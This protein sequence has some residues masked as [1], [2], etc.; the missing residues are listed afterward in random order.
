EGTV[1]LSA[2]RE[3]GGL[4]ARGAAEE[5]GA[6]GVPDEIVFEV[7]DTGIGIAPEHMDRL[8]QAFSQAE[9]STTRRFGGTGL[10]LTISRSFCQMMRGDITVASAAGQGS[11]FTVRL[12]AQV[13]EPAAPEPPM[14]LGDAVGAEAQPV[15]VVPEPVGPG[16]APSGAAAVLVIEDDPDVRQLLEGVLT[17]EGY[18]VVT[19]TGTSDGLRLAHEVHP[20]AITLDL[21]LPGLEGWSL[22]SAIKSDPELGEVP[23][24]VLVVAGDRA[25]AP[26]GAADYLTKPVDRDRLAAVLRRHCVD[27]QAPVLVIDDDPP[28]REMLRRMLEREGFRVTEAGDG[29]AGLERVA[30]H[31]PSLVLLDLLMPGLDGFGFLAELQSRPE[32]RAI[33][34][35]VVTA[36]DLSAEEQAMLSG[37]VAEVLLKGAYTR[38]RL[39]A[40][41]RWRVAAW[42]RR[43]AGTPTGPG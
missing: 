43:P 17:E 20:D 9:S 8:F 40:E 41:V 28:T 35:V 1:S 38:E 14:A 12:P 6:R 19:A 42:T 36:K 29:R 33:P 11:T 24:V 34:V 23:V 18:R 39:L 5:P 4:G 15:A 21:E 37:R 10:G 2:R 26:L 16:P 3:G 30:E 13:A 31:R 27:H 7:A 25:A 22:L 32:W